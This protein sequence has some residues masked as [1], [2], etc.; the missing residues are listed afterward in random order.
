M[1]EN[2]SSQPQRTPYQEGIIRRYYENRDAIMLQKLGDL[3]GD[4]YLSE[5]KARQRLWKRIETAL[6]NLKVP[7][8]RIAHLIKS[9]NAEYLAKLYQ[10]LQNKPAGNS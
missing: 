9:D 3:I 10:E 2:S 8:S 6:R 4:L 7:E 1:S 5:G